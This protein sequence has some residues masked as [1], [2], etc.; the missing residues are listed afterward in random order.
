VVSGDERVK[1]VTTIFPIADI[2]KQIGG[3]HVGVEA[4]LPPGA[5]PHT[6]EPTPGQVKKLVQAKL[7]VQVG[8]G[9]EFW[10]NKLL[11]AQASKPIEV[12]LAEGIDLIQDV[13]L[14]EHAEDQA[15]EG[16]VHPEREGGQIGNPHIWVDPVLVKTHIVP[17]ITAGLIRAAP[18]YRED[19]E[20][21][22]AKYITELEALDEEFREKLTRFRIKQFISVHA[23]WVY[24]AQ[25]YGLKQVAAIEAFPGKEPSAQWMARVAAIAR[26]TGSKV[27]FAEPQ[28]STKA[29]QVIAEEIGGKVLILD[30]LGGPSF[31]D[32]NTYIKLM[33]YNLKTLEEGLQ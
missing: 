24:L 15:G 12:V 5:S 7:F 25:R 18:Q 3:D 8:A 23:A 13:G 17:K 21:G 26:E 31:S 29:A 27:I 4:L 33:R 28:L 32:R 14:E 6:F 9:L 19:F 16:S 30:Y 1:V 2:T 10:V 20:S 11:E 22:M